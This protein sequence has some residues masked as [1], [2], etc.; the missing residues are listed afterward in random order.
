MRSCTQAWTQYLAEVV[1]Q[2]GR[3]GTVVEGELRE[4][5]ELAYDTQ[6]VIPGVLS[7]RVWIKQRN[8]RCESLLCA[9]AEPSASWA[10]RAA[11][12]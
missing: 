1:T 12:D 11:G 8:A 7:S 3:V 9:W 6:W 4:P 5:G 2:S 10:H